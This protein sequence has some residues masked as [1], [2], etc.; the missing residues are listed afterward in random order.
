MKPAQHFVHF[1]CQRLNDVTE[2]ASAQQI[3]LIQNQ[4]EQEAQEKDLTIPSAVKLFFQGFRSL[5]AGLIPEALNKFAS[6]LCRCNN[7]AIPGMSFYIEYGIGVGLIRLSSYSEA[8][9]AF[10]KARE[11][12]SLGNDRLTCRI[13]NNLGYIFL[14]TED[15]SKAHYYFELAFKQSTDPSN[16]TSMPV[17]SNLAFVNSKLGNF[18]KADELFTLY[19]DALSQYPNV[20]GEYFYFS[21][22]ASH[23]EINQDIEAALSSFMH[24]IE[25]ARS[26]NETFFLICTLKEY[27][28]C[29]V[30]NQRFEQLEPYLNQAIELTTQHGDT[31]SLQFFAEVLVT[32]SQHETNLVKK[33]HM[34]EQAFE[35]HSKALQQYSDSNHKAVSQL[36]RL[37]SERPEL[38]N[39]QSLAK[40]LTLIS[41]FGEYLSAHEDFTDMVLR[42]Y[43]DLNTI[44]PVDCLAIGMYD[45]VN[46]VLE[47]NQFVDLGELL[48]PFSIQCANE[49]TLSTYCIDNKTPFVHGQFSSSVLNQLLN[50][51]PTEHAFVGTTDEDYPS[52]IMIPLILKDVVL[53]VLTIQT[54]QHHAYQDYHFS[55]VK[56]LCSYIAIDIQN[57]LHKKQL[58]AQKKELKA[59]VQT[60]PLSGLF[61]RLTLESSLDHWRKRNRQKHSLSVLLIDID[62]YKQFNDSYGHVRGD[63]VLIE[64][65][66]LLKRSFNEQ[67]DK[68]FRYG[69]DEFLILSQT[70][71]KSV[72]EGKLKNLLNS[73]KTQK[74]A[75]SSSLCS[76]QLT[77]SVGGAIFPHGLLDHYSN[78]EMLQQADEAL[79]KVKRRGRDGAHIEYANTIE[80]AHTLA[81]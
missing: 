24:A 53:G 59:L 26:L 65:A 73:I 61:N 79:Y 68:V 76:D 75:H 22:Y 15:Y 38:E 58:E 64:V 40:N 4:L 25:C 28:A 54:H 74:I 33:N 71:S 46:D 16:I 2:A 49:S 45:Q 57:K 27:C 34:M 20:V 78:E 63:E 69:G 62:Y 8:I 7:S 12:H 35:L 21:A 30:K 55:L 47:Y 23:L 39:A 81:E 44:M 36:Y 50:K 52:V 29:A 32:L 48:P 19:R 5:R 3:L 10:T 14:E 70:Q 13:N 60:D 77:L 1:I 72:L 43:K 66:T 6:A 67:N 17:L 37:H 80:Q 18:Q 31:I 42:L 9:V 41:S 11:C 51:A 56:H